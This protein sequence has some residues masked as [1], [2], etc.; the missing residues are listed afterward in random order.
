MCEMLGTEPKE[1]EIPVDV[2]DLPFLVQQCFVI[3]SLLPDEWD[4]MNGGF[5]GK[6][7]SIVFDLMKVYAVEE[8]EI[9][10]AL[11]FLQCMDSVRIQLISE[12]Q[13]ALSK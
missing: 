2:D 10:L 12:K 8:L 5:L 1:E 7:Y 11:T 13:K 6:N 9:P 3:Y 4:T